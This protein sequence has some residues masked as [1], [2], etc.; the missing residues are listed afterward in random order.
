[1]GRGLQSQLPHGMYVCVCVCVYM[2]L[3][4]FPVA[5]WLNKD[6]TWEHCVKCILAF[7]PCCQYGNFCKPRHRFLTLRKESSAP[8]SM[9]FRHDHDRTALGDHALQANDVGVVE[10]AHDAGLAQEV[11]PLLL[12][13]AR[14]QRLDGHVDLSL[15]RQ[16]QPPLYTSPN[17]PEE[18][19]Y[20]NSEPEPVEKRMA[21]EARLIWS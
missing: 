14:L 12:R 11:P 20:A 18:E 1:M 16:F 9:N 13:V 17:S 6:R 8:F 5:T 4:F 10:L 21:T 19:T 3:F 2:A 15:P 7:P